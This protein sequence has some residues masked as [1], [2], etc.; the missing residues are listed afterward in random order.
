MTQR[1]AI[2]G[3]GISGSATLTAYYNAFL[4]QPQLELAIDCYDNATYFGRGL[5]FAPDTKEALMNTRSTILTYNQSKPGDYANWLKEKLKQ[6]EVPN[7]TTRELFGEYQAQHVN[8]HIDKLKAHVIPYYVDELTYNHKDKT[9]QVIANGT[10]KIYDRVHLCFGDLPTSDFYQLGDTPAYIHKPYPLHEYPEK[11]KGNT[12]VAVIGTSLSAIDVIKFL[13]DEREVEQINVFSRSN[14][15]P[16]VDLKDTPAIDFKWLNLKS[17]Q[18]AIFDNDYLLTFDMVNEWLLKETKACDIDLEA[19]FEIISIKGIEGIRRSYKV[20]D[21][22]AVMDRI[23]TTTT[24]ILYYVW[25]YMPMSEREKFSDKYDKLFDLTK[26]N[27][28]KASADR[29]IELEEIG[30]LHVQENIS[31]IEYDEQQGIYLLV[32]DEGNVV[33]Q[34]DWVVNA[35]GLNDNLNTNLSQYPLLNQMLDKGYLNPDPAGGVSLS[36]NQFAVISPRFGVLENLHPHGTLIA[37]SVY[38]NNSITTIQ[39]Y[40]Q[41]VVDYTLA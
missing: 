22:I 5:P 16:V 14:L 33:N 31:D 35:T 39:R 32:D 11:I 23:A 28:P 36:L 25:Q 34:V 10:S 24:R 38:R 27:M 9:W 30:R 13:V 20:A 37:G 26:G 3:M 21:M 40:A 2:I 8:D 15:F 41:Q 6:T 12:R 7:Y 17:I 29:L 18:Q 4:N 1:I 19:Y